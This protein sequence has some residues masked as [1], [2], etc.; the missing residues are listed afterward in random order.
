[1]A[2]KSNLAAMSVEA[3]L[4]LRDDIG[5]T[6]ARKADQLKKELRS[7]GSDYAEVARIA[8]YGK[9]RGPKAKAH[10]LKGR[11]VPP[12]YRSKKNPKLVWSG[13]GVTPVWMRQEMK[14]SKAKKDSFLIK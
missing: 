11:K 3:L 2:R 6:L 14:G 1:M 4:K 8:V 12:K 10:G 13:R 7:L 5:T 9:K